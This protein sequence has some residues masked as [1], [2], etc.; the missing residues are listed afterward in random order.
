MKSLKYIIGIDEAGRGPLAGPVSVG[1][2]L[3]K[4]NFDTQTLVGVNDSKKLSVIKRE[5]V[6]IKATQL[7]KAKALDYEVTLVSAKEID[8]KGIVPAIKKALESGLNKLIKRHSLKPGL[9][10]I[11]LDGGLKAP[12]EFFH[13]ETIIKGDLKEYSIGLASILAKVTRD[14]Y[15]EKI[16]KKE[17]FSSYQFAKHKG[18]GT[19]LHRQMIKVNGLSPEHRASFCRNIGKFLNQSVN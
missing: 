1:V 18:Y 12:A 7:K 2:V 11:K 10:M 5:A 9:V 19:I 16:A 17:T 8:K 6:F 3:L 13:Q 15:M 4:V 14:R